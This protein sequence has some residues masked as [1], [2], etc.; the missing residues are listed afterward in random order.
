MDPTNIQKKE[1]HTLMKL[2]L[3]RRDA[4]RRFKEDRIFLVH[5]YLKMEERKKYQRLFQVFRPYILFIFSF[6]YYQIL[7]F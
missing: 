6:S 4:I 5:E 1:P 2:K 3:Q 7:L